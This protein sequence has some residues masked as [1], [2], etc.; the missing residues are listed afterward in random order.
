MWNGYE[1]ATVYDEKDAQ[2]SLRYVSNDYMYA[3]SLPLSDTTIDLNKIRYEFDSLSMTI[4][5]GGSYG[6]R[7]Y[8]IEPTNQTYSNTVMFSGQPG[9][10]KIIRTIDAEYISLQSSN[11]VHIEGSIVQKEGRVHF[12]YVFRAKGYV[13]IFGDMSLSAYEMYESQIMDIVD[14]IEVLE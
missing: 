5:E 4:A 3:V 2:W 1:M 14:S 10:A 7:A 9:T 8:F 12:T 13:R 6:F 11:G